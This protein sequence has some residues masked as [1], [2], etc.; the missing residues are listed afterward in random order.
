M[1]VSPLRPP[2]G[3]LAVLAVLAVSGPVLLFALITWQV[4]ADGPLAGVD[5]RLS[6]A[7]VRPDRFSELLAD[8]GNVQ[9]A[10]PV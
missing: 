2:L 8:L 3:L 1:P 5:E 10:G 4:V 7:L 9:V 6:R